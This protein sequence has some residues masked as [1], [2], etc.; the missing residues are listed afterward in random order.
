MSTQITN[1][2][3][4]LTRLLAVMSQGER[5]HQGDLKK[6]KSLAENIKSTG[7]SAQQFSAPEVG[8]DVKKIVDTLK[9]QNSNI[10]EKKFAI[11]AKVVELVS[12]NLGTAINNLE[13]KRDTDIKNQS[14]NR[15]TINSANK[16]LDK[17]CIT[18]ASIDS[19]SDSN[20]KAFEEKLNNIKSDKIRNSA[21]QAFNKRDAKM[22]DALIEKQVFYTGKNSTKIETIDI[23]RREDWG[24]KFKQV[25]TETPVMKTTPDGMILEDLLHI[26]KDTISTDKQGDRLLKSITHTQSEIKDLKAKN[27]D[28]DTKIDQTSDKLHLMKT[29]K[30]DYDSVIS[31]LKKA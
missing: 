27:K 5:I 15:K 24:P 3:A 21:T 2:A 23:S 18:A 13:I 10:A 20:L 26:L 17:D 6:S 19:R 1:S 12:S 14:D 8:K 29:A 30:N 22:L 9:N 4:Q 25:S 16:T 11:L 31:T 28:L 7:S